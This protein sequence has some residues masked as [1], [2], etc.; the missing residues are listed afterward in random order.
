MLPLEPLRVLINIGFV[1]GNSYIEEP[2][3]NYVADAK[4]TLVWD[5][6]NKPLPSFTYYRGFNSGF[7]CASLQISVATVLRF[8]M[9]SKLTTLQLVFAP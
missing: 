8:F 5:V 2:V 1:R 3:L 7:Q 6:E 9:I 4:L